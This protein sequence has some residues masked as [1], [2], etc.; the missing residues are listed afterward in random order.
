MNC[1]LNHH[2]AA[3]VS[4]ESP[5]PMHTF[6]NP[7]EF[8]NRIK[9]AWLLWWILIRYKMKWMPLRYTQ[10]D[11]YS[12]VCRYRHHRNDGAMLNIQYTSAILI[13]NIH[14]S[15]VIGMT[16]NLW[17]LF[18][19]VKKYCRI[20]WSTV[21]VHERIV[22]RKKQWAQKNVDLSTIGNIVN[23]FLLPAIFMLYVMFFI[24]FFNLRKEANSLK[25][26]KL[27]SHFETVIIGASIPNN[28]MLYLTIVPTHLH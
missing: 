15:S 25:Q 10:I 18:L 8:P 5:I 14:A 7:T 2:T 11:S 13:Y 20:V 28:I 24:F 23:V 16:C 21:K 17:L 12:G 26:G 3:R 6:P 4:S 1:C 19:L 22:W 27:I 9:S